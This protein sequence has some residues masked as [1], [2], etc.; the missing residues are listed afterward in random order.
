MPK[1]LLFDLDGTLIENSMETFLPPYFSALTKKLTDLV[2][3]ERLIEQQTASTRVMAA[4]NDPTRTNAQVF[5][6]DFFPKIGVPQE[7]LMPLLD[8]FYAHEYC[9]LQ[10]FTKPVEAAQ[11]VLARAFERRHPVVIATAPL[12]PI[13]ALKQRL[14]WGGL[15]DF[16]FTLITDFETM[17]ACKPNPAYY[18]EIAA[19]TK[20]EPQDCVMIGNDVQM[21]ILPSR[22]AGMKT[23]WIT[24]AGGMPTDVPSDWRGTLADFGELLDSG[25]L[26][27]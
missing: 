19:G 27:E 21:D 9:D 11:N 6:A 17:H 2:P 15:G 8:D 18:R 23:F 5:A 3:P 16:P 4:N 1:T 13:G 14:K 20:V 24:D 10:V 12:F 25:E 26:N 22:R 7:K